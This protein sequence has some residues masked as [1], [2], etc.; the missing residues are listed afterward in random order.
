MNRISISQAWAYATSFFNGQHPAHAIILIGMGVA[1][2]LVLNLLMGGGA[3]VAMDPNAFTSGALAPAAVG[4]VVLLGLAGFVVQTGSYFASWRIGLAPDED[5]VG[6]A[7][8]YGL[9][10]ALPMLLVLLGFILLFGIVL[11]VLFGA[12]VMPLLMGGGDPSSLQAA[13]A[14][15]GLLAALPLFLLF[16]LWLSA[17]ICCMGPVMADRRSFN[18]LLGMAESWRM[19]AASQWKLMAYFVLLAI[20][21]TIVSMIFA[22]VA[23]V[24]MLAGGQMGAISGFALVL[25]ALV[26]IPVAYLYVAVP[27]GIYRALGGGSDVSGVFA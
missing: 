24:S 4:G 1:V 25:S 5:N 12:S 13:G 15:L 22:M 16:L 20:V 8:G 10:A 9:I 26:G 17:R 19:T 23:G 14:G 21:I 2:P 27:A 3:A 11:G 18:P 7:I 6:S